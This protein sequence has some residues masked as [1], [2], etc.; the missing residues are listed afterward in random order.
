MGA[1]LFDPVTGKLTDPAA[2]RAVQITGRVKTA[3]RVRIDRKAD[4]KTV[5]TFS[6]VSGR[7]DGTQTYHGSGRVDCVVTPETVR[8]QRTTTK[9]T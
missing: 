7:P 2:L 5:E 1:P 3:P 6:E 8:I 9:E 4:T